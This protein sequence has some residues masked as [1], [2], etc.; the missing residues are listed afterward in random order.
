MI[1]KQFDSCVI[2]YNPVSTSFNENDLDKIALVLKSNGITPIFEESKYKGN[3]IDLVKKADQENTLTLTLGGD[4]TVK[5]AYTGLNMI[6][7]KGIY[8]HVPTGTANDMAKNFD[9]KSNDPK[10][11][12]T[13]ILNGEVT[14]LDTYSING[15]IA[16][17]TSV[18]GYLSHIPFITSPWLKKNFGYYGYVIRAASEVVKRPRKYD[19]SYE[20]D[21]L[22]G[23]DEFILGAI[24]NTKGFAGINLY[25]NAQLNDRKVEMLLLKMPSIKTIFEITKDFFKNKID[26]S[27]YEKYVLLTKSSQIKLTFN[28][29][30]PNYPVDVDGENSLITPNYA[31]NDLIFKVEKPVKVM[32]AKKTF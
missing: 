6:D 13:D 18:F 30:F 31:D 32:K 26:L 25:N 9:V 27:K 8:A 1:K 7:Q 29:K 21:Q 16:A 14:E 5:E 23:R 12:V 2:I 4:A 10:D 11:I 15:H 20:T 28:D 17:Y 22:S 24:S 3:V 19:I